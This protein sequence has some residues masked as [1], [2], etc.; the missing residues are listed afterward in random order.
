MTRQ[1]SLP[2]NPWY[3]WAFLSLDKFVYLNSNEN[4]TSEMFLE[5][6]AMNKFP[7]IFHNYSFKFIGPGVKLD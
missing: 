1:L 2:L 5:I 4:T 6:F 7:N 3:L